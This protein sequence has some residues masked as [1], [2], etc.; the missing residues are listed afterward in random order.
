MS[1]WYKLGDYATTMAQNERRAGEGQGR[2]V[3]TARAERDAG[4][5]VAGRDTAER[6]AGGADA[7]ARDAGSAELAI[8][9]EWAQR[10]LELYDRLERAIREE[11]GHALH[12][13]AEVRADVERDAELYLKKLAARR[14]QLTEEV[15][16]LRRAREAAEA[17]LTRR[18]QEIDAELAARRNEQEA[19]LARQRQE[20]EEELRR[21]RS[22]AEAEVSQLRAT[23]EEEMARLRSTTE[24]EMAQLRTSTRAEID[25]MVQEA[26]A[27]RAQVAGEVRALE[28][29]VAQIQGVIDS[30]LDTQLQTL[31]GSLG[32][33]RTRTGSMAETLGALGIAGLGGQGARRAGPSGAPPPPPHAGSGELEAAFGAELDEQ[34]DGVA[35]AAEDQVA[36]EGEASLGA[37]S[38]PDAEGS[39]AGR[40]S[41]VI[42]GVPHF[43]RARALWQAIQKVPGVSEAKAIN[44]QGGV[45]ALDVQHEPAADLPAHFANLTGLRLRVTEA[46]PGR[47]LLT[48]EG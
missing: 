8:S 25:R 12:L 9:N 45:L 32:G 16:S 5:E 37:A 17:D 24:E 41:V 19:A 2:A 44:Y 29:Q 15:D 30:F 26:E 10:R 33:S 42:S 4:P 31:R 14:T 35:G 28:E 43:S 22:D 34:A 13:A 27:R 6:E 18:R 40:T 39:E 21:L 48:A 23:T 46:S 11:I 3:A 7:S 20:V 1:T 36:G 47:L 38:L